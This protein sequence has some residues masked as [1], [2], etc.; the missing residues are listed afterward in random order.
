MLVHICVPLTGSKVVLQWGHVGTCAAVVYF[1]R[2][3]L[4]CG[5]NKF[6]KSLVFISRQ[7]LVMLPSGISQPLRQLSKDFSAPAIG[8]VAFSERPQTM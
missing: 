6:I 1:S 5:Y 2:R 8:T 4:T 7:T 3:T